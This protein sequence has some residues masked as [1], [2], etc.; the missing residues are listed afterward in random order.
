MQRTWNNCQ[1][2]A[3]RVV[4]GRGL[5]PIAMLKFI[6]WKLNAWRGLGNI[7]YLKLRFF[8]MWIA[9]QETCCTWTNI[10][11]DVHVLVKHH[12]HVDVRNASCWHGPGFVTTWINLVPNLLN[13]FIYEPYSLSKTDCVSQLSARKSNGK[14]SNERMTNSFNIA[15]NPKKTLC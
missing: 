7:Q 4:C 2:L 3:V 13:M 14:Q 12:L 6:H 5:L 15:Q 8:T 9:E 10:F 1:N 11:F